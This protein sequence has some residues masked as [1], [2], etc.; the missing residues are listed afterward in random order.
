MVVLAGQAVWALYRSVRR[1]RAEDL[2][3]AVGSACLL[4]A[5]LTP[6]KWLAIVGLG[7]ILW[8]R[9]LAQKAP[10]GTPPEIR[11]STPPDGRRLPKALPLRGSLGHEHAVRVP[12]STLQ[13]PAEGGGHLVAEG[14]TLSA[15]LRLDP[16]PDE[17]ALVIESQVSD[18]TGR[19]WFSESALP[20]HRL[21]SPEV[22]GQPV[23]RQAFDQTPSSWQLAF[24]SGALLLGVQHRD[25]DGS[26]VVFDV[27][28]LN[29]ETV[30]VAQRVDGERTAYLLPVRE[31]LWYLGASGHLARSSG[32]FIVPDDTHPLVFRGTSERDAPARNVHF[33]A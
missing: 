13:M 32:G 28:L 2:P 25:G 4:L 24:D 20:L 22:E 11:P 29:Q 26:A 3:I 27:A 9:Y 14:P 7:L 5:I 33:R 16:A 30:V 31:L 8:S 15:W 10:P 21:R 6:L 23:K 12:I 17:G 1:R 18:A 19:V